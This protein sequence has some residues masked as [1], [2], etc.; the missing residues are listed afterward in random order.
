MNEINQQ[1]YKKLA[2]HALIKAL[3][4]I[5]EASLRYR[6]PVYP[7]VEIEKGKTWQTVY[8]DAQIDETGRCLLTLHDSSRVYLP[9]SLLLPL[10][11]A[12]VCQYRPDRVSMAVFS[13]RE[14][15]AWL[16][17]LTEHRLNDAKA[18]LYEQK[19]YIKLLQDY[20]DKWE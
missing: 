1:E 9:V 19:R 20:V 3:A 11:L 10:D 7:F 18:I 6:Q 16:N 15:A 8:V 17:R 2:E 4:E 5:E 13:L 12:S 14:I